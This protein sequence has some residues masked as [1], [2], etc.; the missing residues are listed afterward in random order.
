MGVLLPPGEG[1][2]TGEQKRGRSDGLR[3]CG[4]PT[5]LDALH[6]PGMIRTCDLRIRS[7]LLYPAELRGPITVY[8]FLMPFLP[9]QRADH[10]GGLVPLNDL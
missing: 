10:F 5:G 6:A 4:R 8:R 9:T 1:L 7:P 2:N 3:D